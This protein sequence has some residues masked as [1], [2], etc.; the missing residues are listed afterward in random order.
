M[1]RGLRRTAS[2]VEAAEEEADAEVEAAVVLKIEMVLRGDARD[3]LTSGLTSLSSALTFPFPVTCSSSLPSSS[4][5]SFLTFPFPL[6]SPLLDPAAGEAG[7]RFWKRAATGGAVFFGVDLSSFASFFTLPLLLPPLFFVPAPVTPD[8]GPA[9]G[10]TMM[11]SSSSESSRTSSSMSPFCPDA[12][13][14]P[15]L[16]ALPAPSPIAALADADAVAVAVRGFLRGE[17]EEGEGGRFL[18]E[19]GERNESRVEDMLLYSDQSQ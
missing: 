14:D 7:G 6:T 15:L 8:E 18:G 4:A 16:P 10:S 2:E 5:F 13:L 11:R 1:L 17:F 19:D 3:G 9:T 12:P